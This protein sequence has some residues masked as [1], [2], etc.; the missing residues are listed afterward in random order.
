MV[1]LGHRNNLITWKLRY[2]ERKLAWLFPFL[3]IVACFQFWTCAHSLW[4][5]VRTFSE[6]RKAMEYLGL[7]LGRAVPKSMS[8]SSALRCMLPMLFGIQTGLLV[9]KIRNWIFV[10]KK[11]GLILIFGG[12]RDCP[13]AGCSNWFS[14]GAVLRPSRLPYGAAVTHSC[15]PSVS[16]GKTKAALGAKDSARFGGTVWA[17]GMYFRTLCF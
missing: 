15:T 5:P 12:Q 16:V 3:A 17:W 9:L 6:Q 8:L 13:S 7:L 14:E 11:G 1:P 2:L 10:W 4:S